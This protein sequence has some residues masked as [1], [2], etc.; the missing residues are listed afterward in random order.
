MIYEIQG[1]LA[2]SFSA[3]DVE[4]VPRSYN[5]VAHAPTAIGC[6]CPHD[7]NHPWE[8]EDLVANDPH[9][10]QRCVHPMLDDDQKQRSL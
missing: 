5:K 9:F 4:Y 1:L 10:I 2:T 7:A 3:F 8:S 6:K